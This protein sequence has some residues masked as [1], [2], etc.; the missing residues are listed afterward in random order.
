VEQDGVQHGAEHVVLAL[1]ERSVA[2]PY[3]S[4][5][6]VTWQII[7][8]GLGQVAPAV[9]A[10][11]DLQ[12]AVLVRLEVGDELDEFV[13]FPVQVEEVQGLQGEGGVAHPG[14]AVVP[15]A[16]AAGRLRQRRGKC[17]DGGPR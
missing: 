8:G 14:V 15:V 12:R 9:D 7:A 11:H 10:V 1:V 2:D 17:G 5:T 16:L 13:G 4:G 3:R 6:R